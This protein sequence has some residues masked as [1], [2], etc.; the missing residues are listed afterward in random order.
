MPGS[1]SS[2]A[3]SPAAVAL[4][5][6]LCVAFMI[7]GVGGGAGFPDIFK[8]THA[9]AVVSAGVHTVSA[10][11]FRRIFDQ[12]KQRY[13]EQTKAPVTNEFLVQNGLDEQLLNALAQ[14]QALSEMLARIGIDPAPSLVDAQIQK[15]PFAFDRVTGK[16][17]EK[18]F[19]QQLA[20][21]GLTARQ[22][23]GELADELAQRHFLFAVE[24]GL[25]TPRIYAAI[26][27]IAGLENRDISY[28]ILDAKSVPQPAP[29]TDAQLTAFV[30]AH[31]AQLMRPETRIL[32]VVRFSAAALAP[33]VKLDPGAV[34]QEFAFRKDSLSTPETRSLV[35]IPVKTASDGARVAAALA[36]GADPAGLA[37]SVGAEPIRY[38]DKPKTAI[39]D[40]KVADIGFSMSPGQVTGPIQGDLGM[41]VIK[42]LKVTPGKPATLETAR[43]AIEA[44]LRQKAARD[45][46]Y[47]LSQKFDDARQGGA[48][49][50]DAARKVGVSPVTVGPIAA[51]G[52]GPDGKLNPLL[53]DKI[54]KEAF[55]E[56]AG[57]DSDL[58]DAGAGEYFAV[59][60]DRVQPPAL[61]SLQE[62]RPQLTQ[63]YLSQAY[64]QA[65]RARAEALVARL[66]SGEPMDAVAASAGAKVVHQT[67]MERVQARQYAG[68]G[69]DFLEAIFGAKPGDTF[70][71]GGTSGVYIAHL[72]GIRTG[73]V[74]AMARVVDPLRAK[75]TEDYLRDLM[76]SIK[77]A[78][79]QA[80][81]ADVNKALADQTLGVA[82]GVAAK[83]AGT[84]Q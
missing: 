17:S 41:A 74:T 22:A 4:M 76:G 27:A 71:A 36:K 40:P 15:L 55:A 38:D 54:V 44:A 82:G 68:L 43:S 2:A 16:F 63:A 21:Q 24:A 47:A 1:L 12:Q 77:A 78:A 7:L 42:L 35:Q 26:N 69:R 23:Q 3:R 39:A 70:A 59:H 73:D 67:G 29:P 37:R 62:F 51:N 48:S 83:G 45:Q 79:E 13:E 65:I 10:A 72:D 56:R 66:K 5:G 19:T 14:D 50:I 58:Q 11:D 32:T 64:I 30:T 61:P 34:E 28:F 53:T 8:T 57:E 46:A 84:A 6:L 75:L 60:V 81:K 80:V 52:A 25:R 20:S 9:N 49:L 33:T 31:A 18:Q